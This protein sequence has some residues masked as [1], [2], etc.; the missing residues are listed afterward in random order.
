MKWAALTLKWF[1]SL[2]L[3]KYLEIPTN[4]EYMSLSL[5]GSAVWPKWVLSLSNLLSSLSTKDDQCYS[6][7]L[8][9]KNGTSFNYQN[10]L[11]LHLLSTS[12]SQLIPTVLGFQILKWPNSFP[13]LLI[14]SL[15]QL[16]GILQKAYHTT[17]LT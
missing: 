12:L 3:K 7:L 4:I 11:S 10:N 9:Y 5:S 6:F 14:A 13:L 1:S 8:H 15:A 2:W 16:W 17:T